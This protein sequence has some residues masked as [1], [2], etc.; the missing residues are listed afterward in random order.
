MK[1]II[2]G[3]TGMVGSLILKK[4]IESDA[5]D[6]I[7]VLLRKPSNQTPTA[8]V[9]E[10]V[11]ED[12]TNYINHFDK[13]T[14]VDIA[15]FCIG[16]Y[17]GQVEDELFKKITVDYAVE[18]AK[19]VKNS[20]PNARLCLLSGAGADRTEKSR[21]AFAKYKGMAENQISQLGLQFHTFR[22]SY[23]YPVTPRKEPNFI[24]KIT[25]QLYPLIKLFGKNMSIK[26]NELAQAMF[27]VGLNGAKNE[28]LEN[29]DILE[30]VRTDS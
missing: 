24:Y 26:S 11:I 19:M 30:Y 15:F 23:I 6:S 9:N 20:N 28:V 17:T 18:F 25:R 8:K 2:A 21:T 27:Y 1:V 22:P 3:S 10:V 29:K 5:I 14:N 12:F 4:C 7:T 13:F 16:A